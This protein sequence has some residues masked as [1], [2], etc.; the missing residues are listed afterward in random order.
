MF[1]RFLTTLFCIF[2]SQ[3]VAAEITYSQLRPVLLEP[4]IEV[5]TTNS[6]EIKVTLDATQ[7]SG[8]ITSY[9]IQIYDEKQNALPAKT[10]YLP[11]D[12]PRVTETLPLN[13]S[14]AFYLII[15]NANSTPPQFAATSQILA[16]V[17]FID[18]LADP[19]AERITL[20][21]NLFAYQEGLTYRW[22]CDECTWKSR[23]THL[24]EESAG[25]LAD[26]SLDIG[27]HVIKLMVLDRLGQIVG[28]AVKT[29]E[30]KANSPPVASFII[31]PQEV[32]LGKNPEFRLDLSNSYDPDGGKIQPLWSASRTDSVKGIFESTDHAAQWA[33][34]PTL[35]TES[36]NSVTTNL[37][38]NLTVT[39]DE[40]QP[41]QATVSQSIQMNLPKAR[42]TIT[43]ENTL[44]TVNNQGSTGAIFYP[45]QKPSTI[46]K[47]EWRVD[48]V[49]HYE[50][51]T[52][53][54]VLTP[55][56]HQI[57]LKVIDSYGYSDETT[58][59]VLATTQAISGTALNIQGNRLNTASQFAAFS[60]AIVAP[61]ETLEIPISFLISPEDTGKPVDL[62]LVLGIETA[63]TQYNGVEV[64][65]Y[66]I[67]PENVSCV[68]GLF[69]YC[70]VNLYASP[71]VWMAQLTEPYEK[72]ITENN[73]V[74]TLK[75]P[76]S[77]YGMHYIFAGYR[78]PD[79][80]IVYSTQPVAQFEVK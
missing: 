29:V 11:L 57:S 28:S 68:S 33:F 23:N 36:A 32:V 37:T 75:R 64:A 74:R 2:L 7:S 26:E 8:D 45:P 65:Y 79:N 46:Q 56:K 72:V 78:R 41:Q 52:D 12:S 42:F 71:E 66:A 35:I 48:D 18:F 21:A 15:A 47:Y 17:P 31:T 27:T 69:G 58:Q 5:S 39:D 4:V 38:F 73:M 70:P 67:V 76:F 43:Q 9:K 62:L 51:P 19:N 80:T 30:I 54:M 6:N 63:R 25:I 13:T 55:G 10:L 16:K 40:P 24:I 44:F 14:Y 22:L 3:T 20:T 77:V 49:L 53:R 34:K 50:A 1:T 61:L 59:E 60:P